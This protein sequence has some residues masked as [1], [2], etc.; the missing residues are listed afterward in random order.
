MS[1]AARVTV[2][3]VATRR[4][5]GA[6]AIPAPVPGHWRAVPAGMRTAGTGKGARCAPPGGGVFPRGGAAGGDR[7]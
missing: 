4:P 6:V 5:A 7:R 1:A 3:I 2:W